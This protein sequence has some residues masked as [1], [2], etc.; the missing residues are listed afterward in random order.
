MD[1]PISL[2]GA[3]ELLHCY[4]QSHTQPLHLLGHSTGGLLSLLYARQ[5]PQRV[6]SLILLGVG[7]HPAVDWQAHFYVLR[8]L[9]SCPRE[10]ILTQMVRNLFGEQYEP[11]LGRLIQCLEDDLQKSLSPHTLWQQVSI[12]EGGASVPMLICGGEEDIIV[13]PHLLQNW[14]SWLKDGDRLWHCPQG[15]HFF[16]YAQPKL[17][18]EQILK[19]WKTTRCSRTNLATPSITA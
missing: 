12:P 17:V 10:M 11:K 16:H 13:D 8:Q 15:K 19:F 3:V 4:L 18:S 2:D 5:Y 1:E 7:V 14:Q 9:L 6:H